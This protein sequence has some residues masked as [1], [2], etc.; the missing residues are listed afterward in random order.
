MQRSWCARRTVNPGLLA[1]SILQDEVRRRLLDAWLDSGAGAARFAAEADKLLDFIAEE[2]PDASREL[3]VCRLEQLTLRAQARASTF[4]AP[5][6]TRFDAQ[7]VLR[8][9]PDAGMLLFQGSPG[10]VLT[11]LLLQTAQPAVPYDMM[12]LMVAPGL[13]PLCRIASSCEHE[14]WMRLAVPATAATLIRDGTPRDAI[15]SM[16]RVGALEYA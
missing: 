4:V 7:C 16:L 9:A 11:V 8:R 10:L 1:L 6:P 5:D 2:L 15:E 3:A 12:T 13:K 14:L